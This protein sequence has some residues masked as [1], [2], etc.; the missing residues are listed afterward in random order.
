MLCSWSHFRRHVRQSVSGVESVAASSRPF[1]GFSPTKVMASMPT[2]AQPAKMS[3]TD[4]MFSRPIP[5]AKVTRIVTGM[6]TG[7]SWPSCRVIAW[8]PG[9]LCE[10]GKRSRV[11]W[12]MSAQSSL[13]A[14]SPTSRIVPK[15]PS[16]T[17]VMTVRPA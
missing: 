4:L 7:I 6:K 3:S 12:M 16:S 17:A 15:M 10:T 2:R 1:S 8:V 14:S 9:R 13:P 5:V 11:T